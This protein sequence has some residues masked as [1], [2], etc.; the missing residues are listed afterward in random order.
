MSILLSGLL[1]NVNSINAQTRNV[2]TVQKGDT[3]WSICKKYQADF[4]DTLNMN[5]HF[6]DPDMIYPGDKVY[7]PN[8]N[9]TRLQALRDRLTKYRRPE[10]QKPEMDNNMNQKPQTPQEDMNMPED[11]PQQETPQQDQAPAADASIS[12][13]EQEVVRLVN[14]ERQKQGLQPYK[15]NSQVS[16]I[17]RR[18]SEDMRDKKYFSHQSPTYGSP[19]EML[20]Q[21]GVEFTAAGENI[22]KGQQTAAAV[23]NSWMNSPGHRKNILSEKFT[24]IGVGLAK[25]AN[26]TTYWTQM[27]IRP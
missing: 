18:K 5:K 8:L 19:F 3:I 6:E 14:V 20:N 15:H 21:F 25:D 26:G 22:A 7:I 24:E 1:L 12:A 17:A 13:L 9:T 23:M 10:T 4:M 16:N 27:F 2:Y 11:T